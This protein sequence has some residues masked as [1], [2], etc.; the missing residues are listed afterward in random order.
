MYISSYEIYFS[1]Q[2]IHFILFNLD[3]KFGA[4]YELHYLYQEYVFI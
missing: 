3:T 1:D 2:N 4:I